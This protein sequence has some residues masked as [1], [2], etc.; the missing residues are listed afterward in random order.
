MKTIKYN[1]N[2]ITK[3]PTLAEATWQEFRKYLSRYQ[4]AF[5]DPKKSCRATEIASAIKN[6]GQK[7][8]CTFVREEGYQVVLRP[9]HSWAFTQTVER[10]RRLYYVSSGPNALLYFDIDLHHAWQTR[11]EGD[12]AAQ[13]LDRLFKSALFW[14]DS[15]RGRNGYLKVDL[16]GRDYAAA[17]ATFAR[18]EDALRRLL[19]LRGNLADFEIK[20]RTGYLRGGTYAWQQYGKLPVH[21][22]G[23][24][25]QRLEEFRGKPAVPLRSLEALC[26]QIEAHIPADVLEQHN[27]HKKSLGEDPI[28]EGRWFLVT[29]AI[30][31]SLVDEHGE[32]WPYLFSCYRRE[33]EG[34]E[35]LGLQYYRPGA[36]PLTERE[37]AEVRQREA[38]QKRQETP[39]GSATEPTPKDTRARPTCRREAT[40]LPIHTPAPRKVNLSLTD[41]AAEPDSFARQ[42]EAL[43]RLA[44][45][46]KRVPA[47][48][49]ALAFLREEHLFTGPW[50]QHFSRRRA[51]VRDILRF[52]ARTFDAGK[53][54]RG[55][56]NV[57]KYDAWAAE[58]FPRGLTGKKRRDLTPD[59]E[60]MERGG[61]TR[62]KAA[63]LATFLAVCEFAIVMNR[64]QDQTLPT[65]RAEALW[66]SLYA[67]GLVK[68]R[69]CAR[70]WAVCR[71]AM[72][73]HGVIR[74]TDRSYGPGHAMRWDVGP[75]FPFLGL[76]KKT[77]DVAVCR[78]RKSAR[79]RKICQQRNT[80]RAVSI[81]QREEQ[82]TSKRH[83][84]LL[85]MQHAEV[86]N[87]IGCCLPRPPPVANRLVCG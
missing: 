73:R 14:S 82:A 64:N 26:R 28:T 66:E 60:V 37:L 81:F 87:M 72:I 15:G 83:N 24:N 6:R 34:G 51:R 19:A 50:E 62:A 52:I 42:R 1:S 43:V 36:T 53:C 17:N 27:A 75:Y 47:L 80:G 65:K 67:K 18:L 63:F 33:R 78:E 86:T 16:R 35:W 9:M 84:T 56:V 41:L 12:S 30:E 5:D 7:G 20:G 69:F 32:D 25:F 38:E 77:A 23:W 61:V 79:G 13:L 71:E 55:S 8:A 85:Y 57:G 21:Q 4:W 3:I 44:R 22:P 45:S 59:G 46:L 76:W 74:I 39:T 48:Y 11:A 70:K 54:A 40:A 10:N 2:R 49:E 58:R 31:K 29:P 68:V